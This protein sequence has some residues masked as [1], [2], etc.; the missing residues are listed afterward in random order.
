MVFTPTQREW[1]LAFAGQHNPT[2]DSGDDN[3]YAKTGR[4]SFYQALW[5]DQQSRMQQDK[6]EDDDEQFKFE[7]FAG[8]RGAKLMCIWLTEQDVCNN[9]RSIVVYC[10][11]KTSTSFGRQ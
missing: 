9:N 1:M 7:M 11:Y 10:T 6:S 3:S 8:T 4:H 5:G 2:S